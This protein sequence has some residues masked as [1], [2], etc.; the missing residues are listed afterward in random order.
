MAKP[1]S[2]GAVDWDAV[3]TAHGQNFLSNIPT[4]NIF[5]GTPTLDYLKADTSGSQVNG[6]Y[7]IEPIVHAKQTNVQAVDRMEQASLATTDPITAAEYKFKEYV[8]YVTIPGMDEKRAS[9]MDARLNLVETYI[10]NAMKSADEYLSEQIWAT[11][12]AATKNLE[13]LP[14]LISTDGTGTIGNI[15]AGTY[16]WWKNK[17][18]DTVTFST[19]GLDKMRQMVNDVS[20][21]NQGKKPGMIVT[22]QTIWE[23]YV[24]LAESSLA[25]QTA[26]TKAGNRVADL[27]FNVAYYQ[28]IPVV[29]DVNCPSGRM[30]FL[31]KEAIKFRSTGWELSKFQETITHGIDARVARL[32]TFVAMTVS[33]RRLLGQ[34]STIS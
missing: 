26:P 6:L 2:H 3:Y 17:F 4:D 33:N 8:C 29:W 20:A 14:V 30:Y 22:T 27:G 16:T 19:Q 34:I 32:R 11:S 13:P 25:L 21:G 10:Q 5:V 15:A 1:S 31:N 9:G 23:A 18:I 28:G 12:Q 24:D 7:L